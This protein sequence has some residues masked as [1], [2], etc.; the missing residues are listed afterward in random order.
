MTPDEYNARAAR[1]MSEA[2]LLEHCR[3]IARALGLLV[4]H[5]HNSQRSEPGFPDLVVVGC[6]GVMFRELKTHKGRLTQAQATWIDS[7]QRL[8]QDAHI[9]RPED[10]MAGRITDELTT[11]AGK[12]RT[13]VTASA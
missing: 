7:L 10:L 12:T 2:T 6:R 9:W 13:K 5:T 3:A 4:Y 11:I 8:G 1:E